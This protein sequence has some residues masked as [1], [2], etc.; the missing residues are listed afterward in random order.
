MHPPRRTFR[1]TVRIV[2]GLRV[3]SPVKAS[4]NW[5][6]SG[7]A[8]AKVAA[9]QSLGTTSK[10]TAGMM[11]IPVDLACSP[12]SLAHSITSYSPVISR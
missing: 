10:P 8:A 1:Q 2:P 9:R 7:I 3:A 4:S 12:Q 6:A 5:S 11:T